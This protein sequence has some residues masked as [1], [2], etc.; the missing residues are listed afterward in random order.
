MVT[1]PN[2]LQRVFGKKKLSELPLK[3]EEAQEIRTVQLVRNVGIQN[4]PIGVS[5]TKSYGGYP[6]EE[7]LDALKGK[8]RA[9][10]FDK[11]IRSDTQIKMCTSAVKNTIK[12]AKWN[13][14]PYDDSDKAV[15]I[16]DFTSK[17]LFEYIPWNQFIVESLTSIE[18]G[19]AV[20]EITH[21]LK[22]IPEYGTV[23]TIGSLGWRS[24]RTI[25][26]WNIENDCLESIDQYSYGDLS[27]AVRIPAE[28]LLVISID[29]VGANYEGISMIR[30]C[31]GNFF[32]K[33]NY[34]KINGIGIERFAIPTPIAKIESGVQGDA[35]YDQLA[36]VLE[37]Y[38]AHENNFLIVNKEV[39]LD[40]SNS[41]YDP[42]K[43]EASIDAEDRRMVKAFIAN[44]LE[45]G[46]G[47]SGGAFALSNDLSDF[48]L[49]GIEHIA[50]LIEEQVNTVIIPNLI[51]INFGEQA[52][53]PKLT[54]TGISD[55]AGK[56]LAEVLQILTGAKIIIPDDN[57]EVDVRKRYGLPDASMEGQRIAQ[58]P[59]P[60]QQPQTLSEKIRML[61]HAKSR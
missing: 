21:A 22:K 59:Q 37:A 6:A 41:S 29:R 45:L 26:R 38:S 43:V 5:G 3:K 40:F 7:Y 51:K 55:K 60:F 11:M 20:F 23:Y 12:S 46:M 28:F 44:F 39:D 33:D 8:K 9:D 42:S 57:L 31:Y 19:N 32:R 25:E 24:P 17:C 48:F 49:N 50:H 56:E 2:L 10:V 1:K 18:Y 15:M 30:S 27:R 35:S 14:K 4:A 61:K 36:Y 53:Y 47:Q 13:I 52:G 16:A 54:H 34:L 58:A